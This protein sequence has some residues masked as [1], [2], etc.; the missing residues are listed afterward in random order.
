M[1]RLPPGPPKLFIYAPDEEA[2]NEPA[3]ITTEEESLIECGFRSFK[4]P[5]VRI[6]DP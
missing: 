5:A 6:V 2:S 4:V 1:S 3:V